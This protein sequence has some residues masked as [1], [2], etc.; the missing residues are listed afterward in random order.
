[1]NSYYRI[2]LLF[3][4]FS[5]LTISRCGLKIIQPDN[6]AQSFKYQDIPLAYGTFGKIDL[7]FEAIGKI[8]IVPRE[9][10][11]SL[12]E[13]YSCESLKSLKLT[14]SSES[15]Q[16]TGYNIVLIDRGDCSYPEMARQVQKIGGDM[17]LIINNEP[18]SVEGIE[19]KSDGSDNDIKI[20]VALI[21]YNDGKKIMVHLINNPEENVYLEISIGMNKK[22][23]VTVEF[24]TNIL[25]KESYYLFY[26]FKSYYDLLKDSIDFY[27]IFLTQVVEGLTGEQIVND[28]LS[29]GLFCILEKPENVNF[30]IN[31]IKGKNLIYD[32]IFHQCIFSTTKSKNTFFEFIEIY[33]DKC[34]NSRFYQP[35]CGKEL[36]GKEL[37]DLIFSCVLDSFRTTNT[38]SLPY[39][40]KPNEQNPETQPSQ[41]T[42]DSHGSSQLLIRRF[43]SVKDNNNKIL[44]DNRIKEEQY[45][46]KS[47]PQVVINGKIMNDDGRL[48]ASILFDNICEAFK[49]KPDVC[50]EYSLHHTD[51]ELEGISWLEMIIFIVI[52]LLMNVLILYSC[53]K[54]I[55]ERVEDRINVDRNELGGEINTV[56]NSYFNLREIELHK[57][58]SENVNK[59]NDLGDL[60]NFMTEESIEKDKNDESKKDNEETSDKNNIIN[61]TD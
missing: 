60:E 1:M 28:C 14:S 25:N 61:E 23:R 35:L 53:K 11:S 40:D 31:G 3:T 38:P 30:D 16:F 10:Q 27:P 55:M 4:L 49:K 20:P 41:K 36:F 24:F 59:A 29:N 57:T 12:P 52:M 46:I 6:L 26:Q 56:V 45:S 9:S 7:G 51:V 44:V 50:N 48:T 13:N 8:W 18:G 33:W 43:D 21:S 39:F 32:S 19:V 54:Y 2:L 42:E 17:A 5:I 15:S 34:Y 47:V 37:Q 58:S 22:D